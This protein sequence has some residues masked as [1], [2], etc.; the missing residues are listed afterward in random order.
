VTGVQTCALP[1]CVIAWSRRSLFLNV[2]LIVSSSGEG[3][4]ILRTGHRPQPF[5][6]VIRHAL[7]VARYVSLVGFIS[8]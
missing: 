4:V 7:L 3:Y 1:I 2:Y 5:I 6:A 8:F